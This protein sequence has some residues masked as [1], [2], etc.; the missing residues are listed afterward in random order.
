ML[1]CVSLACTLLIHSLYIMDDI[2]E[3]VN[4]MYSNYFLLKM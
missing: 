3:L 1:R 4:I 2:F